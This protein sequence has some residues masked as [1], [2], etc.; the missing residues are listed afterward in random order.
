[1]SFD[2]LDVTAL[3]RRS[4][5]KWAGFPADVL[6]A[7][8]ADMDF[9][10]CPAI[11]ELLDER[12]ALSDFGYPGDGALQSVKERFAARAAER[13][14]WN[15]EPR[16]I[17]L[18]TD[19]VQGLYVALLTCSEPGEA[20]V[21][22]TPVYP[23]FLQAV[24]ECRRRLV[25][26]PLQWNGTAYAI[27]FEGLGAAID[28]GTRLL[29]FCNPQNPTGRAFSRAELEPLAALVLERDLL[30][31]SDEIHADL[32]YPGHRHVPFATLAPEIA[33]RTVT[34]TSASKAFNIAG[35]RCAVAVFG[36]D[37]LQA[38]FNSLPAHL[39]GGL[40]SLGLAATE[41][42]WREGQPWLDE[43]LAYLDA[44]RDYAARFIAERLPQVRHAKP[45]ATYL[46]WLDCRALPLD[47]DPARFFLSRARVAL[48]DGAAFGAVGEGFVRLNF[49]TSRTLL[50]EILERMR[51]AIAE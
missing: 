40:S 49:A 25:L 27:D 5:E 3:R 47:P 45:E 2:D 31:C 15:V 13:F 23:P 16:R 14:G 36:S 42:A 19:V 26:N 12:V 10:A 22:Q 8:V 43:A 37:E 29:L 35:L 46:A 38:R 21:V 51:A 1:M 17:E 28:A 32:V 20:A 39:R 48:S 33:A 7:W 50:A 24:P 34:L 6:P 18:L 30:V 41:L 11:R 9:P 44:N 4:G